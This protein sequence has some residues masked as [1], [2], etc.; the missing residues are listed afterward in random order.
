MPSLARGLA[1]FL[2]AFTLLNLIG[3]DG[4]LWWIDL[5]PL[6]PIASRLMLAALALALLAYALVP[7]M[8]R[9]RRAITISFTAAALLAAIGNAIRFYVLLHRGDFTTAMPLPLSLFV[10]VALAMLI[11][12]QRR[13]GPS[14]RS[15]VVLTFVAA[16]ILF[17]LAQISLFGM[18]DYRRPADL[19]VVFGARAY[20]DGSPS[21]A[22]ADRVR[23]GCELY[24]A[25]LAPKLFLS[26]GPGE[27]AVD[28]PESMRRLAR[29]LG[30]PDSAI[31]RDPLG[32]NT[33]S[34]VRNALALRPR[35]VLAVSHFYHLP[36]IKMTCQRYG[37][38]AVYTVPSRNSVPM[39][40]PINLVR[41]DVAFWAYYLR[42][43]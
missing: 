11:A 35:R 13:P 16:A 31:V 20:A 18:T 22:L 38:S 15:L 37:F 1:L 10:A 2:G 29:K 19:I 39:Q 40:M 25:G 36:R 14:H 41:E 6:P 42:R 24:R 5:E 9:V 8:S 7:S 12:G 43:L 28:E 4:N 23:T 17:P 21:L 32:V 33:E 26:G 30:V 34:T 3:S 27:G